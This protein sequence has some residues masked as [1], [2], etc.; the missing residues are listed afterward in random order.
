[1]PTVTLEGSRFDVTLRPD[2]AIAPRPYWLA[3]VNVPAWIELRA[4]RLPR[5]SIRR[6][7]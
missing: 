3:N 1:M 7:R 6:T 5:L 4:G 2:R